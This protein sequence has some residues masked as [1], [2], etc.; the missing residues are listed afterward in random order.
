M[1]SLHVN[2]FATIGVREVR[3]DSLKFGARV[4][5]SMICYSAEP[6]R[7]QCCK[8]LIGRVPASLLDSPSVS[9]ALDLALGWGTRGRCELIC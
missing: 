6:F 5:G 4:S 2:H 7:L 9:F 3:V 8:T 1:K